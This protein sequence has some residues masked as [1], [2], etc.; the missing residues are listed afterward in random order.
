MIVA[1]VLLSVSG[2]ALD[3]DFMITCPVLSSPSYICA[4][5]LMGYLLT[6]LKKNL[7][8]LLRV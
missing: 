2:A 8:D 7:N 6:S 3:D 5:F 4:S 1:M